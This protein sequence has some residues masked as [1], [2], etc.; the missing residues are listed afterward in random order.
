MNDHFE[1]LIGSELPNDKIP[2]SNFYYYFIYKCK[3]DK[4]RIYPTQVLKKFYYKVYDNESYSPDSQVY[5]EMDSVLKLIPL[6]L[7][8][9]IREYLPSGLTNNESLLKNNIQS[10]LDS[11]MDLMNH[12]EARLKDTILIYI[13]SIIMVIKSQRYQ[14]INKIKPIVVNWIT[15]MFLYPLYKIYVLMRNYFRS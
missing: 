6:N 8:P 2:R 4:S 12:K 1:N 15:F 7:S 13:N 10:I 5:Y 11:N 14:M 3:G 9:I